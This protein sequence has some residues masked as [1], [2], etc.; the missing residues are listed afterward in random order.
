MPTVLLREK[1]FKLMAQQAEMYK[2]QC[3]VLSGILNKVKP[4]LRIAFEDTGDQYYKN[5]LDDL[6]KALTVK[7]V[8]QHQEHGNGD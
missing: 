4:A 8:D 5:V 2:D 7:K 6:D 3:R 1:R